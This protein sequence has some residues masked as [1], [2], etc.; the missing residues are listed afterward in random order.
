M[1]A[2]QAPQIRKF[3][4]QVTKENRR[5]SLN[6]R[7]NGAPSPRIQFFKD[8]VEIVSGTKGYVIKGRKLLI[9]KPKFPD[10]DGLYTCYVT[11]MFGKA[12]R[13]ANL[14]VTGRFNNVFNHVFHQVFISMTRKT[15][16]CQNPKKVRKIKKRANNSF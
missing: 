4:A 6:C 11:N 12:T 9:E 14:T 8:D 10:H 1:I 2:A 13:Q 5:T 3:S 7:S 16:S 15:I